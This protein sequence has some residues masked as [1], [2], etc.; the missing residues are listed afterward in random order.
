MRS[1]SSRLLRTATAVV[2]AVLATAGVASAHVEYVTDAS[3]RGDPVAF[4]TAALSEPV[5]VVALGGGGVAV[6]GTMAAYLRFRPLRTDMRAFRRALA[7]YADLLPWL[8]RLAIGLPMLGAGF[9]G[10]L[11][12]PLLTTADTVVPIRL[13][14]VA[15]GFMLLF[16]LATRFVAGVAFAS[17]LALLPSHPQLFFAFEY[18]AGLLAIVLVG[19]GRPSADHVIARMAANE[20]TVYSQ[21]D[22]FYRRL[23]VPV[24][25][26]IDPYRKFVPTVIRVGMGVVFAYLAFAEKL[27]APAQALAVVEKYGLSTLVP[28]PPELWVLGASLTELFLGVLLVLGFFTRASS[29]AA[30]VVFTT[31]LFGLADDPVLAHISLFGLVSALLV[32]GAGPFAVDTAVFRAPNEMGTPEGGSEPVGTATPPGGPGA[33]ADADR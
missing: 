1:H 33:G 20:S 21:F 6:L 24:G 2:G 10:Y 19:G 29:A 8:L 32:T 15:V 16:G 12:T 22:P 26:R 3:E 18:L 27:L 7:D 17:Y 14:G 5:V 31:T 13:F 9:A 23:A 28:V 25:D 30:F 11:F 4:M